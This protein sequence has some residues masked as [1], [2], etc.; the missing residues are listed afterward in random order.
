MQAPRRDAMASR[1]STSRSANSPPSDDMQA[2]SK[3]ASITL[4]PTGDKP[5]SIGVDSTLTG[6]R[7]GIRWEWFNTQI[8]HRISG[9]SHARQP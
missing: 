9:L 5:G 3:R 7:S 2:A 6:M 4:P 8:L 1:C